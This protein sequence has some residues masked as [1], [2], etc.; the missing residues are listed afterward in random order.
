MNGND[1]V[2]AD[3]NAIIYLFDGKDCMNPY[4]EKNLIVS[5]V[6]EMELLSFPKITQKELVTFKSFFKECT[7]L[8]LNDNIKEEAIYIRRKYGTKLPDAIVAA[9][10]ICSGFPLITADKGFRKITELDL[11]ILEP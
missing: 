5:I 11:Q 10:S 2:V 4:K 9:T 3:S 6:T 8:A 7:L 1:F